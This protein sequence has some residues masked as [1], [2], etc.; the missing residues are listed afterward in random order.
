MNR[1]PA[2]FVFLNRSTQREMIDNMFQVTFENKYQNY[3]LIINGCIVKLSTRRHIID[4][5]TSNIRAEVVLEY[6]SCC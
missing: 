6:L 4:L 1:S 3:N 2:S 5:S